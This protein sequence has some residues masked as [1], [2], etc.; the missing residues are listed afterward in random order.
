MDPDCDPSAVKLS[1]TASQYIVLDTNVA[2]HQTDL[3]EHAAVTDVIVCSVVLQEVSV[4]LTLTW[5]VAC[6]C[7]A[8]CFSM[9]QAAP[10]SHLD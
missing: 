9:L 6:I 7:I 4:H 1:A 3:L 2:L 10:F 5:L 8:C